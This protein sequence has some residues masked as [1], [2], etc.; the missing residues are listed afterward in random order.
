MAPRATAA[1]SEYEQK[2]QE[3]I[4]KNKALFQNLNLAAA[5][6]GLAPKR[7]A[8]PKPLSAKRTSRQSDASKGKENQE[9]QRKSL[10]LQ[11]IQPDNEVA[12]RKMED[13]YERRIEE[14]RAKKRR[15]SGDLNLSD[16]ITSG[17]NWN[18]TGNFLRG[19]APARPYVRSFDL[20]TAK[21]TTDK[22]VRQA[23]ERLSGLKLWEDVEPNSMYRLT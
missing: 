15:R 22:E 5:A 4:A 6:S 9:P 2:R 20:E 12:K 18:S 23:V 21:E 11:N 14:E 13:A 17:D 10:R 3:Q 1:L 8:A 19:V 16:I 7:P